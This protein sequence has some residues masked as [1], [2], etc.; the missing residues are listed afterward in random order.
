[1]ISNVKVAAVQMS[2]SDDREENIAKAER[3]V[4]QAASDGANVI[5]LPELFELPYFCQEKN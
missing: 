1:M 3:M 2:C 5:L 4:R